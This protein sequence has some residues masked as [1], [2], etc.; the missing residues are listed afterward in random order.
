MQ[1]HRLVELPKSLIDEV[2][3]EMPEA[4]HDSIVHHLKQ[5]I[6]EFCELSHYWKE[7]IGPIRVIKD[8]TEY[9]IPV[10][11]GV[12][13][14]SVM[15]VF[16]IS[17]DGQELTLERVATPDVKFR[18]WQYTPFTI[19]FYPVKELDGLDVSILTALKP[20]GLADLFKVSESVLHDY[21][22][23]IIAG[24]KS[25]LYAT[26]RKPWSDPGLHNLNKS[27]FD[28]AAQEALR[29]QGRGYSRLP[30]RASQQKSRR[31]Y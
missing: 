26:P 15:N 3:F 17:S 20:D 5:S 12:T 25:R 23:Q 14:V 27:I 13:V 29:T 18:F 31:F 1:P 28:Q 9:D 30:D 21:Q 16:A 6:I 11:Q 7:N 8:I 19:S 24:A 4:P 22:D 10:Y 2:Q